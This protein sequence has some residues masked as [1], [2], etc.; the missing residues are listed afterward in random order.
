MSGGKGEETET[1]KL[2]IFPRNVMNRADSQ[3]KSLDTNKPCSLHV[4]E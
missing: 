2:L 3:I 4:E 1:W